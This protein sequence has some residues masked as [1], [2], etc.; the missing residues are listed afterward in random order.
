M[1]SVLAAS[2]WTT[3]VPAPSAAPGYRVVD[4]VKLGGEGGWDYLRSRTIALDPKT[5]RVFLSTAQLGPPPAPTPETPRPRPIAVP[6]TFVL[7]VLDR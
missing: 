3:L 2:L 4:T 5:H 1:V 7:L 6:G